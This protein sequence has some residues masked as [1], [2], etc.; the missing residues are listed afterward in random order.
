MSL[1]LLLPFQRDWATDRSRMKVAVKSRQIGL[2]WSTGFEAVEVAANGNGS[3]FWY[4][5]YAAEDAKLFIRDAAMW[6]QVVGVASSMLTTTLR[7]DEAHEHF[8]LPDGDHSV[9]VTSIRFRSGY[10]IAALP[11]P[12]RKLRGKRGVGCLDEADYHDDLQGFIEAV[13]AFQMWNG[14]GI[15]ISTMGEADGEFCKLVGDIEGGRGV[16]AGYSLHRI[17]LLD[18][19]RDGLYRRVCEKRGIAW[20]AD[21]ER[22]WVDERLE[23][24]GADT[25]FLCQ[26]RRSGGQ[27]LPRALVEPCTRDDFVVRQLFVE[28]GFVHKVERERDGFIDDWCRRELA[29]LLRDAKADLP[30]YVGVDFGRSAD[31]TCMAVGRT[32]KQLG[33]DVPFMVELGNVPYESQRRVLFWLL[34]RLPRLSRVVLDATGNGAYLAEQALQ[35]WGEATIEG[36]H[37][38]EKW[39]AEHLPKLRARFQDRAIAIPRDLDV[40]QDLGRFELIGGVPKMPKVRAVTKATG[41]SGSKIKRHGDAG[42]ALACL[43]AAASAPAIAYRYEPTG[44]RGGER[45]IEGLY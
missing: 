45:N 25:E 24:E 15:I 37:M 11:A 4:Q 13:G 34:E 10:Q 36:V 30:H 6:A 40:V 17:T 44:R 22:A 12:P 14:R 7:G 35:R 9:Q 16:R 43:S 29:P 26:P 23:S 8:L 21:G 42:I 19:V 32:T 39:Y 3:D 38:S 27:Y 31:M 2:T 20:T 41:D 5:C 1:P 28:A 18:A 33:L